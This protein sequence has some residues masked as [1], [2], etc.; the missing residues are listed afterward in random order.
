MTPEELVVVLLVAL[1]GS[2]LGPIIIELIK[3]RTDPKRKER[4]EN[5]VRYN[6]LLKNLT[7][8]IAGTDN[9][10]QIETFYEH[11][12]LA[13]LYAPDEV[14]KA[15]NGFLI[16]VGGAQKPST[17]SDKASRKMVFEIR[18]AF[19]GKTELKP[20]DFLI[21]VVPKHQQ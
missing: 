11:Y 16:A 20:D 6:N 18:K 7:G 1:I 12:R 13:W 15:I 3:L 2:I 10:E 9:K 5:E 19:K 8:F 17:E 21:I 4:Q 14:I